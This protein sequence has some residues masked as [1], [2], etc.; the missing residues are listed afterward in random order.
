MQSRSIPLIHLG[1]R[2]YVPAAAKAC[3][4]MGLVASVMASAVWTKEAGTLPALVGLERSAASFE[5]FTPEFPPATDPSAMLAD[6]GTEL[7]SEAVFPIASEPASDTSVEVMTVEPLTPDMPEWDTETR[8]FD[9]RPIRP[10]KVV[11]MK[12]TGYS[13]DNR[14]C[15]EFAD[16]QTATLHSVWTNAMRLVA[17]DPEVLPYGSMITVPGYAADQV[18]PV[19]DCGGAIKGTRLDL[20]FPTHERALAWGVRTIRVTVWEYADGEPAPNPRKVR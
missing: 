11:V 6:A 8:W 2:A 15:G 20:L 5:N 17:A 4:G 19:L 7:E 9:G 3:V 18:V 10:S 1:W 13:P 16:G 14:S 12:V